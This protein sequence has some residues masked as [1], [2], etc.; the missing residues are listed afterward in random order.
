RR[1][2]SNA[3]VVDVA[4]GYKY[5]TEVNA[6]THTSSGN[7]KGYTYVLDKELN[8]FGFSWSPRSTITAAN[9]N[10]T[11]NS[12]SSVKF[13]DGYLETNASI[14]QVGEYKFEVIDKTYTSVDSNPAYMTHHT[15]ANYVSASIPDCL[16]SQSLVR[17]NN[18]YS[19]TKYPTTTFLNGC[20]IS[21]DHN[22][23]D[24]PSAT[25]S[26]TEYKSYKLTL[27]PYKFDLSTVTPLI[28]P[29]NNTPGNGSYVY[30]ESVANDNNMSVH[31]NGSVKALGYNGSEL[32]NFVNGC[33][34]KSVDINLTKSDINSTTTAFRARLHTLDTS[35]N[36][37]R[38][39]T[40][41]MNQTNGF[42]T[43]MSTDFVKNAKGAVATRLNLNYDRS[44]TTPLNP[45]AIT[46]QK[47]SANCSTPASCRFNAD[48][49]ST[50]TT[51]GSKELN[52][53]IRHY[54]GH[55]TTTLDG[56][57]IRHIRMMPEVQAP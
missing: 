56:L 23:T 32:S 18:P 6:T 36:I 40:S 20:W 5:Y 14:N 24:L 45:K 30:M 51:Q 55:S 10:D 47:Y 2:L 8:S 33:F 43:L 21:S 22:N 15:G 17:S 37:T 26:Y 44:I 48:N 35:G 29:A 54:Y 13:A 27:H 50:K 53:T 16:A 11:N 34:A 49:V 3:A 57:S 1:H 46:Y 9:C 31:L 52:T 39:V 4:S 38:T 7:A 12:Y 42:L 28:G 19:T 25:K 41:D